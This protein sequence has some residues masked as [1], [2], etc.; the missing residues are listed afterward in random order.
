[1]KLDKN[2]IYEIHKNNTQGK[3]KDVWLELIWTHSEIILKIVQKI[4]E[5]LRD[6]SISVDIDLL[7]KGVLLHDIGVYHCYDEDFNPGNNLPQYI[8]HGYVGYKIILDVDIPEE[9][10]RF[11]LR[12]TATGLTEE[13]IKKGNLNLP[14]GNYIPVTLEEEILT[15]A[16]KFHTKYPSFSNFGEQKKSLEKYSIRNSIMMDRFA[17]KFGIPDLENLHKEY[18]SWNKKIDS[19]L[20]NI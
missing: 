9:I 8:E 12:H 19:F 15:Y 5:K 11:A 16:D 13:D 3:Y 1:M 20:S 10:A 7:T 6:E 2:E 17:L 4:V 14:H 18:D